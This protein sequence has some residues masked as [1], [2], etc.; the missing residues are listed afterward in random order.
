LPGGDENKLDF[1]VIEDPERGAGGLPD[2][3]RALGF[4]PVVDL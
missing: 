1:W 4:T 3:L 2:A